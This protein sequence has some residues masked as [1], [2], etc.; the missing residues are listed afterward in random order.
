V[1][2][3]A[4]DHPLT[5]GWRAAYVALFLVVL[6]SA[7]VLW[8][9]RL[10]ALLVL[11][12]LHRPLIGLATVALGASLALWATIFLWIRG[13]GLPASAFPPARLVTSGPFALLSH[14]IYVGAALVAFGVS[15][16]TGSAAGLWIVSPTLCAA[17]AAWVFGFERELTRSRFGNLPLPALRLPDANDDVPTASQRLAASGLVFLPWLVVSLALQRLGPAPDARSSR[18]G[19]ELTLAVIPWTALAYAA[20]YPLVVCAPL[21]ARRQRHLRAFA[22]DALWALAIG[23]LLF[24]L[25]PMAADRPAIP[26]DG[27]LRWLMRAARAVEGPATFPTYHVVWTLIATRV[28]VARWPILRVPR[29]VVVLAVAASGL[30]TGM[31]AVIDVMAAFAVYGMVRW[32]GVAWSWLRRGAERVAN[33]WREWAVGPVRLLN[34]GIYAGVGAALGVAVAVTLAGT[35][36]LPWLLAFTAAAIVGAAVWAQVVEGSAQLLRPYGYFGGV[37][38]AIAVAIVAHAAGADGWLLLTA[39]GVGTTVTQAAGRLRCLVQGC[40]HGAHAPDEVGIVY[41]HPRSRV[42]RLSQLGGT[43]LHPTPLYSI[44]SLLV[45]GAL[46]VRLWMVGAPLP[47]IAGAY[48][49]LVGLSRFVEEHYRG[50]PQTMVIGGL[51][52]YQWL[53]LSFVTGGAALTC[54]AGGPAPAPSLPEWSVLLP[55]AGLALVTYAAYGVD[56]PRS[57]RRFARL[58]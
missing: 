49:V 34:H 12:P 46:L 22:L 14:P 17:E 3:R 33:S 43:P 36:Q 31:H 50:E 58:V 42:V 29:H 37:F 4:G 7:L 18:S 28:Y 39:F 56:F 25:V 44:I 55:L 51:R 13:G 53:A 40:C 21:I 47:F 26:G 38:G 20:V 23:V 45:I 6:P 52:L 9:R 30:T 48:F 27:A 15:I 35:A 32:R 57:H 11:P 2:P 41:T 19:W 16:V 24:L 10:D 1:H 8:A 54:I 5:R